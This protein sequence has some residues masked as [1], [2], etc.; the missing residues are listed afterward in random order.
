MNRTKLH[1]SHLEISFLGT[2]DLVVDTV[3]LELVGVHLS[4]IVLEFSNQV[5][6]LLASILQVILV[7]DKLLSYVGTALLGKDIFQFN[8]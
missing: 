5:L 3:D 2:L 1:L 8:V 7:L 4:L 6:E